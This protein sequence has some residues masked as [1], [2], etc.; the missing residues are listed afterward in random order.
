MAKSH[1]ENQTTDN[2]KVLVFHITL[3]S[4]TLI[5]KWVGALQHM[6]SATWHCYHNLNSHHK[7]IY[8]PIQQLF[9]D[10]VH[11]TFQIYYFI[12][13]PRELLCYFT[14]GT[15]RRLHR[16][17]SLHPTPTKILIAKPTL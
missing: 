1:K 8:T 5:G 17:P 16:A 7:D 15:C 6:H 11:K 4:A 9:R 10:I 12:T 2:L 3:T 14:G 13:L